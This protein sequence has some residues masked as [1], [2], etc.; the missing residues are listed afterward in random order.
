MKTRAM[1]LIRLLWSSSLVAL[2]ALSLN[3]SAQSGRVIPTP[4]PTPEAASPE[5]ANT[6]PKFVPDPNAERYRLIFPTGFE[7][8]FVPDGKKERQD[9]D[10]TR[11]AYF[12]NFVAQL[13]RAG[14]QGYRLLTAFDDSMVIVERGEVQY[15][16]AW[17]ETHSSFH[18]A[19]DGFEVPFAHLSKKG[20][21]L[22][23]H[24]LI[25]RHC[26]Y[27]DPENSAFGET[28][29]YKDFFLLEREKGV[30]QPRE[31]R[32]AYGSPRWRISKIAPQMTSDIKEKIGQGFYPVA[33][34]S[35]FEVLLEKLPDAD[36]RLSDQRDVQIVRAASFW[37]S[38]NMPKKAGEL[39]QEGYRLDLA[40]YQIA[41]MY[42]VG[43]N[44][45][46][47]SY[48]WLDAGGKKGRLETELAALQASGAI[49]RMVYPDDYGKERTLVFERGAVADH[50]RYEY[51]ALTLEV[52]ETNKTPD[53][54]PPARIGQ[55]DLT[56]ESKQ[57]WEELKK[58]TKEGFVV[59]TLFLAG[60]PRVL[61]ERAQ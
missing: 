16:Y 45:T 18:F 21:R 19:K 48:V 34:I 13:N 11:H 17:F 57:A 39:A 28:C 3:V 44:A 30:E 52:E 36:A 51:R 24:S 26:E 32:M 4:S 59:R 12:E 29:V 35:N 2:A 56:P 8:K 42:R 23:Y 50:R 1:I 61:L 31:Y 40:Y 14:E 20:F 9:H 7:R 5:E 38:D 33:L 47:V 37:G 54:M 55:Y 46:P 25:Y 60:K 58:L 22:A 49:F 53:K 10:A 15:E 6:K 27:I 41:V 43:G